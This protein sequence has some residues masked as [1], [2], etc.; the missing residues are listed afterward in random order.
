MHYPIP[1]H[2]Q[3]AYSEFSHLRFPVAEEIARTELSIPL[4]PQMT[5]DEIRQVVEALHAYRP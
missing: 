2:R 4:Y 1:P 5:E 3:K